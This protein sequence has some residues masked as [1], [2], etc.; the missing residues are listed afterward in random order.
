MLRPGD[1]LLVSTPNVA[2]PH[3]RLKMLLR[4][5]PY[6]FG[7]RHYYQPGHISILPHWML[8]EH[9]RLAG[10]DQIVVTRG[11]DTE[12]HGLRQLVH[13]IETALLAAIGLRARADQGEGICV[14]VTAVAV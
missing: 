12:Y 11:G 8:T 9:V 13:R 2:H 10:F 3:S 14:F 1:K 4:G 5:A 6:L 7:P